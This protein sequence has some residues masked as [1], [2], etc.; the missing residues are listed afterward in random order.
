MSYPGGP[1]QRPCA[2]GSAPV[3]GSTP[4]G[5]RIRGRLKK[6]TEAMGRLRILAK[7]CGSINTLARRHY[8]PIHVRSVPR[9]RSTFVTV[10]NTSL[11]VEHKNIY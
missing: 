9:A 11:D 7:P 4:A 8:G 3:G 6:S 2:G 5:G 10:L 1:K